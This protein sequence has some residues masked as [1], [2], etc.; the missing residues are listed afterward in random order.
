MSQ[1]G[2]RS[3]WLKF[4]VLALFVLALQVSTAAQHEMGSE[5][6]GPQSDQRLAKERELGGSVHKDLRCSECHGEMEIEMGPGRVDP[7]ETCGSCHKR[8][9]N[10]YLLSV[11]AVAFRRGTPHTATCIECHGSHSVQAIKNSEAPT[12]KLLV[13]TETCAR[14][15]GALSLTAMHR[16]PP[17]VVPDY[18]ASFHGLFAA[19]GD[20]RVANCASCHGYHEIRPSW[21]PLS[22]VNRANLGQTCGACHEGATAS[23]ATGGIHH[24]PDT[25][26]H[27]V[28]DIVRAMYLMMIT[29]TIGL[30]LAHNGLDFWGRLRERWSIRRDRMRTS[31]PLASEL[32]AKI[33]TDVKLD[34]TPANYFRFSIAERIQHWTLAASFI[35]LALTGFALKYTWNIPGLDAQQG[36]SWRGLLH[37]GAAVVF[38]ALAIYH[39]GYM[40]LTR[41]GRFNLHA[42]VPRIRSLR[43]VACRCA[44][45]FRLGP[46]SSLDWRDLI[47]TVK[48]N[49]GLT[50]TRPAMGRFTYAEKMEYFALIWGSVVM[51][52]TGLILWF[53]VPFLNRFKYWVF[54]LATVVH[55]YEA[56]LATLAIIVWHFYFTIFN[57]HVFPLSKTMLSGR[58]SREE[59]ERD[60][61]LEL[62]SLEGERSKKAPNLPPES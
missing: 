33:P 52:I 22:T 53:A 18:R 23:F 54:D 40:I 3:S 7:V 55:F 36:T 21:D 59:M 17:N 49:V 42:L 48:Y 26:G 14:C 15:H 58:I 28:V 1:V 34:E 62:N 12:S 50:N 56:V 39:V 44:A 32:N 27:K 37:R 9:L 38:I 25:P 61:A 11:H 47:Q 19:L 46:P 20:Q 4:P 16:L 29:I 45:C 57:P 43:D 5:R 24:R 2:S 8:A 30:M 13:S 10:A 60:H 35:L 6:E 41:R 31:E 51:I